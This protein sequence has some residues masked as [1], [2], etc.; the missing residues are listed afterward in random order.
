MVV[1]IMVSF[2]L[3]D[4]SFRE[5]EISVEEMLPPDWS[6]DMS[7]GAFSLLMVDVEGPRSL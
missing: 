7:V 1:N 4:T 2:Y 5:E 6:V 3:L